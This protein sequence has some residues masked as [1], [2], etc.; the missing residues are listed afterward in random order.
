[1]MRSAPFEGLPIPAL[2]H[3]FDVEVRLGAIEDHGSTRSGHR[4]V[5]PIIGG[6]I[7]GE[8][9]AEILPG[10]ADWQIVRADG[11]IDLDARYS[12][13]TPA[14]ELLYLHA[15]GVRSGPPDVLAA[16][17]RGA[18]V[19]PEDYYFRTT[20]RVETS[21]PRLAHL[22]HSLYIAAAE[23]R[24]STVAYSAYRVS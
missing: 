22:E 10:G 1:M 4:R 18:I 5:V 13:R 16:L 23:R 6:R 8:L 3:A 11:A 17:L 15:L 20:V 9:D 21:S 19:A 12:A 24:A 14:G 2:V 7:E